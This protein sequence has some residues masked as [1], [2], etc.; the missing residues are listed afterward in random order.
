MYDFAYTKPNPCRCAEGARRRHRGQGARRWPDLHP[1]AEAA[2][3]QADARSSTCRRSACPASRPRRQQDHDRRDDQP[4]DDRRPPTTSS[5]RS[6]AWRRWRP[7]SATT[8]CV[9]AA[10]WAAALANNDPVRLLSGGA[11]GDRRDDRH[12]QASIEA[13]DFFQGMFTTALA[14]G[15]ARHLDRDP[16][17]GE[18]EL[19]EVPQPGLA[20]RHGRR[21]RGQGTGGRALAITG[22]GQSGVFR[23]KEMEAALMTNWSPPTRSRTSRRR[24]RASTATSTRAPNIARI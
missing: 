18:V 7:G 9:T 15:R 12:R 16:D 10:P 1:G 13:D 2:L 21:V 8:R 20:L 19:R 24:P 22:A 17:P 5:R 3:E 6:R 4:H 11:A 14:A 23:H